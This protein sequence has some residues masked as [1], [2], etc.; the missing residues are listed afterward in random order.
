[1]T[2][3]NSRLYSRLHNYDVVDAD[4]KQRGVRFSLFLSM[5]AHL[6]EKNKGFVLYYPVISLGTFPGLSN[7][8]FLPI[9]SLSYVS[10]KR[11]VGTKPTAIHEID[12]SISI[13][14]VECIY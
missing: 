7:D 11:S 9:L 13:S 12:S 14:L 5:T 1:M 3:L 4:L 8:F 10:N 2:G 6:L